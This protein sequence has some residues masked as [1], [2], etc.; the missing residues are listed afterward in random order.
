MIIT[1]LR[2]VECPCT[3]IVPS[4]TIHCCKPIV[5]KSMSHVGP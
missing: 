5:L 3:F 4:D 1:I 2:L